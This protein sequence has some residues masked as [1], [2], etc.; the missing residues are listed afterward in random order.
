M[1][2]AAAVQRGYE[3]SRRRSAAA[4]QAHQERAR[5]KSEERE[6]AARE[7][8]DRRRQWFHQSRRNPRHPVA[9]GYGLAWGATAAGASLIAGARGARD[10]ARAGSREGAGLGTTWAEWRAQRQ[11]DDAQAHRRAQFAGRE[12]GCG[13]DDPRWLV[14]TEGGAVICTGCLRRSAWDAYRGSG[15]QARGGRECAVCGTGN[16]DLLATEHGPDGER[17]VCVPCLLR[18]RAREAHRGEQTRREPPPVLVSCLAC[19]APLTRE[20]AD[21][22][23]GYCHGCAPTGASTTGDGGEPETE[24][25]TGG[26]PEGVVEADIVDD[27]DAPN[28]PDDR[29]EGG[30]AGQEGGPSTDSD[31]GVNT[32][33]RPESCPRCDRTA[34]DGPIWPACADTDHTDTGGEAVTV[35]S[36]T[37]SSTSTE[38]PQDALASGHEGGEMGIADTRVIYDKIHAA[39][40]STM[41]ELVD[42]LVTSLQQY[43]AS[44]A[45]IQD[46]QQVTEA[47][48][49]L[50]TA[51]DTARRNHDARNQMTEQA[52]VEETE[53][54]RNTDYHRLGK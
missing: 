43:G 52:A 14:A 42:R 30:P 49:A 19:R 28:D 44:Q 40:A 1:A 8:A 34:A 45:D 50:A 24:P 13:Q 20:A 37:A 17:V 38:S 41:G 26:E 31:A 22:R 51:A 35:T 29:D 3:N 32:G 33:G 10:G 21:M 16:A 12:C 39:A 46:A 2:V 36:P 9:W 53:A 11:A 27:P 15:G 47:A 48:E 5:R 18:A 25:D 23:G 7:R 54:V 6:R 4:W